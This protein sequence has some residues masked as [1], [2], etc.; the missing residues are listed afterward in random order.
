MDTRDLIVSI[1]D[2]FSVPRPLALPPC[3]ARGE[4]P[5]VK[6]KGGPGP[7]PVHPGANTAEIRPTRE[8]RRMHR[9]K[10]RMLGLV[11][12]VA[13]VAGS[14]STLTVKDPT[15]TSLYAMKEEA[16]AVREY[17][18]T[19]HLAGRIDAATL[20]KYQVLDD[21]FAGIYRVTIALYLGGSNPG[22]VT[23][24]TKTLQEVLLEIRRTYY[25]KGRVTWEQQN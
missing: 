19:E 10:W 20:A 24:N 23:A 3:G 9:K 22:G 18:I 5:R 14:C 11:L 8:E 12:V 13:L 1:A 2:R 17:V 21:K 25:P 7:S 4:I 6:K 15:R 16:V